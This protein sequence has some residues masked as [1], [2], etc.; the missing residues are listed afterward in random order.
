M[1]VPH[2]SVTLFET[3]SPP[4]AVLCSLHAG[5]V[6]R[7]FLRSFEDDDLEDSATFARGDDVLVIRFTSRGLSTIVAIVELAGRA[8]EGS[9]DDDC[10]T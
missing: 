1:A 10:T 2:H 7:G 6:A 8:T 3:L 9:H 4:S 5:L